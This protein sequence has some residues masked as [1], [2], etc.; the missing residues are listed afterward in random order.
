MG[1]GLG[2]GLTS[3]GQLCHAAC[4]VGTNNALI[5]G[6]SKRLDD[7]RIDRLMAVRGRHLNIIAIHISHLLQ[8]DRIALHTIGCIYSEDACHRQRGHVDVTDH[9][10]RHE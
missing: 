10:G 9:H 7:F 8:C 6:P 1:T 4:A 5:H 3:I 2:E